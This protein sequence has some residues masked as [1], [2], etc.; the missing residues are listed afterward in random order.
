MCTE[1]YPKIEDIRT[2]GRKKYFD[3][4]DFIDKEELQYNQDICDK[5]NKG[6]SDDHTSSKDEERTNPSSDHH[7]TAKRIRVIGPQHPTLINSNIDENNIFPQ[8]H[9]P[10]AYLTE[11]N[12]LTYTQAIKSSTCDFCKIEIEK[13]LQTMKNLNVWSKISIKREYKLIGTS[14]F[15]RSKETKM[16]K[17]LNTKPAYVLRDSHRLKEKII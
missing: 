10:R 16:D 3:C 15:T 6:D 9:R 17:L 5:Q 13:E 12:S 14:W 11:S 8:C 1:Q 2:F 7:P 4:Q